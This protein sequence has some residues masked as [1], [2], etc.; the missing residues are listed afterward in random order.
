[1]TAERQSDKVASV[2]VCM[3]QRDVIKFLH[4]EKN[5]YSLTGAE[6]LW[7]PNSGYQHSETVGD[8]FYQW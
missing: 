4:V 6:H 8:V 2:V 5:V 7:R 1:M 3:K